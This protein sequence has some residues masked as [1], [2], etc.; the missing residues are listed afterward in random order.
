VAVYLDGVYQPNASST[1][2]SFNDIER[3]EVLKGRKALYTAA[4]P[5]AA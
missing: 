3:I 4:T 5:L 2:F 1:L